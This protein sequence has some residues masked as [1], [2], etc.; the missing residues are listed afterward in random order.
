MVQLIG[1]RREGEGGSRTT[2]FVWEGLPLEI[3]DLAP[4]DSVCLRFI[5]P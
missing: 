4:P 2:N 3:L 5:D 1:L